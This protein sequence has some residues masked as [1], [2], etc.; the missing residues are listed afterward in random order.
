LSCRFLTDLI[1]ETPFVLASASPRRRKI[2]H[3][4][5]LEFIVDPTGIPE[6]ALDGES[7]SDHVLRLS[8]A[9]AAACARARG[10]GT[11][12]GADT[13]VVLDGAVLGKPA[14]PSDAV[15]M[16]RLIRGRW[17]EVH[18][19]LSLIRCSDGAASA[20]SETTRVLVRDLTDREVADYVAGGEPL[21]K[22]GAYAIQECGAAV[23]ERVEGCFYNVVGLPVVRLLA[24]LAELRS[25][26]SVE[27]RARG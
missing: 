14:D 22:A 26:R 13:V 3:E 2:L 8:R 10:T 4:L 24:L 23:V 25:R 5:G 16:L 1:D 15:R 12:L 21:D 7:P 18:T 9:K 27:G 17:H 19:G 11:V 6:D 20:G